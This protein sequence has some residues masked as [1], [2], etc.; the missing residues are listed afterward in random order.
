MK[1]KIYSLVLPILITLLTLLSLPSCTEDSYNALV[2]DQLT[3]QLFRPLGTYG[4]PSSNSSLSDSIGLIAT[5]KWRSL[6]SSSYIAEIS[7]DSLFST[8]LFTKTGM[9]LM[10]ITGS[11]SVK[12]QFGSLV[13][14]TRYFVR[15]KAISNNPKQEDSGYLRWIITTPQEQIFSNIVLSATN[16]YNLKSEDVDTASVILRWNPMMKVTSIIKQKTLPLPATRDTIALTGGNLV[17]GNVTLSS[18]DNDATYTFNI[19]RDSYLRGSIT[20]TIAKRIVSFNSNGG[21]PVTPI[22]VKKGSTSI[23]PQNPTHLTNPAFEFNGWYKELGLINVFDFAKT[24]IEN[25]I[26][27]YAKWTIRYTVDFSNNGI[28]LT[29]NQQ[30]VFPN[31]KVVKPSNPTQ[32]PIGKDN[33]IFDAWYKEP[34]CI[35]KFNFDVDVIA[36]N[37]I[38]YAKWTPP[39]YKITYHANGGTFGT[40]PYPIPPLP[41]LTMPVVPTVLTWDTT[42]VDIGFTTIPSVVPTRQGVNHSFKGW[43]KESQCINQFIFNIDQITGDVN[44]YA[45]WGTETMK[46]GDQNVY[47]TVRI[48]KQVWITENLKTTSYADG[49]PIPELQPTGI[50]NATYKTSPAFCKYPDVTNITLGVDTKSYYEWY[51]AQYNFPTIDPANPKKIAPEGWRVPA[52]DDLLT[53][54]YYLGTGAGSTGA[55]PKLKANHPCWT[56][57]GPSGVSVANNGN[58]LSGFSLL[59]GGLAYGNSPGSGYINN[60]V[61]SRTGGIDNVP[62]AGRQNEWTANL[63]TS[64]KGDNVAFQYY[65][66]T[67]AGGKNTITVNTTSA[68]III[69]GNNGPSLTLSS[70]AINNSFLLS[71]RL[72][73]E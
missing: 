63:W 5:I 10:Y 15:V 12:C 61:S 40:I 6:S 58:N 19:L 49:T 31:D 41:S 66:S 7:N 62:A 37:T 8:V 39:S 11:D 50:T 4:S 2:P 56:Y 46:D 73:K 71:V 16:I 30:K 26:K 38:L 65:Y 36:T 44:L 51:G 34:T 52:R 64:T 25:N 13:G 14:N 33:Y 29:A 57:N 24:T 21:T 1:N 48:G 53:L 18:L 72:V 68:Y 54:L 67:S 17:S 20:Q 60:S 22:T 9:N 32:P 59:A 28:V 70:Y 27:L 47:Q 45:K 23:Q 43:Y 69:S 35:N 55:G 3:N 42:K